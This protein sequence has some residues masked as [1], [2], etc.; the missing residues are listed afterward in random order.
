M[1][2]RAKQ[3]FLLMFILALLSGCAKRYR[4]CP[5]YANESIQQK[6]MFSNQ[7]IAKND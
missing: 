1:K 4:T 5:T 2:N 3:T 7:V 6:E